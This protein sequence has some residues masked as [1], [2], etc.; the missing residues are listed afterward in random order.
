MAV[1][2]TPCDVVMPAPEYSTNL[3]GFRNGLK[4]TILLK[5]ECKDECN[6]HNSGII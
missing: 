6:D 1:K 2:L 5:L 4:F 3:L